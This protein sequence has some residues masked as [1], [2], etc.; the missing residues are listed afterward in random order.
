VV[1]RADS[2]FVKWKSFVTGT[3]THTMAIP[4]FCIVFFYNSSPST[5]T[6]FSEGFILYGFIHH[7]CFSNPYF[8]PLLQFQPLI[9]LSVC[10]FLLPPTDVIQFFPLCSWV[11]PVPRC[12]WSEI[13]PES[14]KIKQ[15][16]FF[17][18]FLIYI[19]A[20][21]VFFIQIKTR[22]LGN[23]FKKTKNIFEDDGL[24][25]FLGDSLE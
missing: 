18:H 9:F 7:G 23:F 2:G 4:A 21:N 24:N 12:P 11:S 20:D 6:I 17:S 15:D 8:M 25:V 16:I 22:F 13:P 19:I 10:I 5:A 14:W 3:R 1:C